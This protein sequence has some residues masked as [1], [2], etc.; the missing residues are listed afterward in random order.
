MNKD[1]MTKLE[2]LRGKS[3]VFGCENKIFRKIILHIRVKY[4]GQ[5]GWCPRF[6]FSLE[7]YCN[8]YQYML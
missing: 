3:S 4:I 1:E 7:K 6:E 5:G 2:I 8:F